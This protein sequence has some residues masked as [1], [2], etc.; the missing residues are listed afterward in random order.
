VETCL[1]TVYSARAPVDRIC[2]LIRCSPIDG[3]R[4]VTGMSAVVH[5]LS[6]SSSASSQEPSRNLNVK[7][8]PTPPISRDDRYPAYWHTKC[9]CYGATAPKE[10]PR[11]PIVR[12]GYFY[13]TSTHSTRDF[14]IHSGSKLFI[15]RRRRIRVRRFFI[16]GPITRF[17]NSS[18]D[19]SSER[20]RRT[21]GSSA[22]VPK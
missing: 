5:G 14:R 9:T 2:D 4:T 1:C 22:P 8:L 13:Q 16:C 18:D 17:Q 21:C 6:D 12:R 3:P 10:Q 19:H 15:L 11:S 20:A 7:F